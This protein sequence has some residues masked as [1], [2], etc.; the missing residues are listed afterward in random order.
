[1]E[2]CRLNL[3]IILNY[4]LTLPSGGFFFSTH[5][6]YLRGIINHKSIR[7]KKIYLIITVAT[8]AF[9]CN[10]ISKTKE[11]DED[12]N[13]YIEWSNGNELHDEM[14]GSGIYHFLNIEREK[15]YVFFE[16]AVKIDSTS[17]AAHVMLS[18]LSLP[19]SEQ[20]ELHYQLAKTYSKNKNENSKRFV[21]LLDIK[22]ENGNR[23]IWGSTKEKNEIWE[24]MYESEPSSDLFNFTEQRQIQF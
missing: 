15:A 3:V 14:I 9:S 17:F 10:E 13:N 21:T 11:A 22:S 16:K 19:N 6:L 24:K 7:M 20:Q 23:G 2:T 5:S 4:I 12:T 8:L 1:M 18:T